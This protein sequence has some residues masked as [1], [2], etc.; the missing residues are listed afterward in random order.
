MTQDVADVGH[1]LPGNLRMFAF[2]SEGTWRVASE[3]ISTQRSTASRSM[4]SRR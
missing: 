4:V 3:M 2:M 1:I